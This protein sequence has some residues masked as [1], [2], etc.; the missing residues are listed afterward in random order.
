MASVSKGTSLRQYALTRIALVIPMVFILLT[1]VFL[2]MRVA[3]GDPI[4]ASLGG[5]APPA[6]INQIKQQLGYDG[7]SQRRLLV[8]TVA[9]S[10]Y[11]KLLLVALR[12]QLDAGGDGETLVALADLGARHRPR[13]GAERRSR[14]GYIDDLLGR[15][16]RESGKVRWLLA[17]VG[18][19]KSA[20]AQALDEVAFHLSEARIVLD[21]NYRTGVKPRPRSA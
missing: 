11:L 5:H 19:G 16:S 3:P 1:M 6:V 17:C 8:N 13:L 12:P 10:R 14:V 20:P 18:E 7:R 2:L 4:S 9:A 21:P 15:A